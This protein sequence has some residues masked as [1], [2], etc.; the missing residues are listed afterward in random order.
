MIARATSQSTSGRCRSR[1]SFTLVEL[2][3][4]IAII[5]LLASSIMFAMWNVMEDTKRSRT[6]SQIARINALLMEKYESYQTRAVPIKVPPGTPPRAAAIMRLNAIRELMRMEMPDRITDVT[7]PAR[8]LSS[9]P[10]SWRTYR[11]QSVATWSDTNQGAECLYLIL[12]NMRDADTSALDFFNENEV[13]DVDGDG[14]LEILDGWGKPID[15]LRWAPGFSEMPGPDGGWG[16][17]GVDDDGDGVTDNSTEAAWPGSDD[18]ASPSLLQTRNVH[19]APDPFD[20]LRLDSRW[21]DPTP[22]NEPFALYPLIFSAGE[23]GIYDIATD[24][25]TGGPF[26]AWASFNDP[27]ASLA[28][29]T[30]PGAIMD[31]GAIDNVSNHMSTVP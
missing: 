21:T 20:P 18:I 26:R 27:Y 6:E 8:V 24:N 15:F 13:G 16:V 31:Q 5:G 9:A 1:S 19:V 17:T 7:D 12:R 28:D 30:L 25:K 2:L 22:G 14:M 3:M 11:R 4:V 10:S 29:G 23:D